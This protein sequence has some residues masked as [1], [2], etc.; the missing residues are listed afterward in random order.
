MPAEVAILMAAYNADATIRQ[1]V[2]SALAGVAPCRVFVV[3]DCSRVPV[4][5]VLGQMDRVEIIRLDKNLGPA[6][7]RNAGLQR[8]LAAKYQYVAI[9]DADDV[10]YPER[11]A[12]QVAFLEQNPHVA[13]VGTW[14]RYIDDRSGE[15]VF[16]LRN[17]CDPDAVRSAMFFNC[18]LAN[19]SVMIRTDAI[20][21]VGLYSF[22]YPAA[23]DYELLRRIS[24]EFDLANLPEYLVDFRISRGGISVK[25][26]RRQLFDRLLIQMKYFAPLNWRAWAGVAS[27]LLLF[28][29][30]RTF[31]T[32]IKRLRG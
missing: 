6:G 1:A 10:S 25:R 4:S 3:D 29:L 23:E 11:F 27:T 30:P 32:A 5:Q 13:A 24:T 15:P 16:H 18:A 8:I 21:R 12:R 20:V 19:S 14:A 17:V 26:R 31:V 22:K 28:P 7:A 9:F 2:E